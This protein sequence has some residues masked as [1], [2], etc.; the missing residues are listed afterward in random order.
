M[1]TNENLVIN[2][3]N[4]TKTFKGVSALQ[5]LS[6]AVPKNSIFGFLGPNGA[7]KTTTIKLLLGLSK[8]TSGSATI[9]GLDIVKDSP[10]IRQRTGYLAQ[11]PRY[12]EHMTARQTL[13]FAAS[14]F[15]S[16]PKQAIEDR[17]DETLE[18][19]GLTD[20]ADRPIKGFSGGERQ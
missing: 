7:G 11:D 6:L 19:V 20:K 16:G 2:T 15:F 1:T 10:R 14:F 18:L 8:P 9:F 3:Q 4:L 12:Y 17:I 5:S 13:R